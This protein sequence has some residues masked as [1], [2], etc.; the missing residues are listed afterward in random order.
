ME[1]GW[2]SGFLGERNDSNGMRLRTAFIQSKIQASRPVKS[3]QWSEFLVNGSQI[4]VIGMK[5]QES[6]PNPVLYGPSELGF[7]AFLTFIGMRSRNT[8]EQH[9]QTHPLHHARRNGI[10]NS[11]APH[12]TIDPTPIRHARIFPPAFACCPTRMKVAHFPHENIMAHNNMLGRV[13]RIYP[14]RRPQGQPQH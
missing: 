12:S 1:G 5:C 7:R 14:K 8:S 13:F 11:S 9:R 2:N 3:R 4:E 6:Q 10:S